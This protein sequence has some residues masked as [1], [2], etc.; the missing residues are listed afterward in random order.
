MVMAYKFLK[1]NKD[2]VMRDSTHATEIYRGD[3]TVIRGTS[4][5][6]VRLF[7]GRQHS[8]RV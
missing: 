1:N 5:L 8:V 6:T 4:A 2:N 7:L 3:N